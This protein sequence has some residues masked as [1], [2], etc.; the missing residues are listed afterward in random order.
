[1]LQLFKSQPSVR[2]TVFNQSVSVLLRP[3]STVTYKLI[4]LNITAIIVVTTP[5]FFSIG[6]LAIC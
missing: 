1:M 3:W 5:F 4:A 6:N 2:M